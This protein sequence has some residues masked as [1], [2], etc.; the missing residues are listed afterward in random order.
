V[1]QKIKRYSNCR[2]PPARFAL[3][4]GRSLCDFFAAEI[5]HLKNRPLR[6]QHYF[7]KGKTSSRLCVKKVLREWVEGDKVEYQPTF[8]YQGNTVKA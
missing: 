3:A 1:L 2:V 4:E 7:F 5:L 8:L 6:A